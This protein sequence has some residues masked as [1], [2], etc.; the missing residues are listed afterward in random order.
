MARRKRTYTDDDG[1]QL[2][3]QIEVKKLTGLSGHQ[4]RRLEERRAFPKR[5][6]LWDEGPPLYREDKILE[7]IRIRDRPQTPLFD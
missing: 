7:W 3:T 1:T 4:I 2:L 5:I 6:F